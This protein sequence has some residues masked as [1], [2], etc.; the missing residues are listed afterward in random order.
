M[1]QFS[2]YEPFRGQLINEIQDSGVSQSKIFK[3]FIEINSPENI[4]FQ[5][6]F[7]P[8]SILEDIFPCETT[9]YPS[10]DDFVLGNFDESHRKFLRKELT[11]T[12]F[13][14]SKYEKF[15][16]KEKKFE[17]WIRAYYR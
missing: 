11:T 2:N 12:T 16:A 5:Y 9:N 13:K 8:K 7:I 17:T 1:L 4:A 6:T 3:E 15:S 10:A 14:L